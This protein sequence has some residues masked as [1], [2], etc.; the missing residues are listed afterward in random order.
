MSLSGRGI[1]ISEKSIS[2]SLKIYKRKREK[3]KKKKRAVLFPD[4]LPDGLEFGAYAWAQR[5]LNSTRIT[6]QTS[7]RRPEK[8]N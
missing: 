7:A 5:Q 8:R 6:K 2:E 4:G 3:K 1:G